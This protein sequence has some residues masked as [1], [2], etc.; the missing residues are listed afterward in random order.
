MRITVY[1]PHS[2]PTVVQ[3][4]EG[5]LYFGLPNF[6]N[7]YQ[8]SGRNLTPTMLAEPGICSEGEMLST[9]PVIPTMERGCMT[10]MLLR[11]QSGEWGYSKFVLAI[12]VRL[13][14][15]FIVTKRVIFVET[16]CPCD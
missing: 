6:S 15:E 11:R 10:R 5:T 8:R 16:P 9:S 3:I 1:P 13:G 7:A 14:H 4:S 12:Y 2:H